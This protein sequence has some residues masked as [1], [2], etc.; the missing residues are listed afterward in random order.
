[1]ESFLA[2]DSDA[3]E[4]TSAFSRMAAEPALP[5]DKVAWESI[6]DE[7]PWTKMSILA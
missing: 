1:M 6:A 7:L 4:N 3:A 5:T 2:T